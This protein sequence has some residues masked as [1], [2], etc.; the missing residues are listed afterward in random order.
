MRGTAVSEVRF[1]AMGANISTLKSVSSL[2]EVLQSVEER[3]FDIEATQLHHEHGLV[4]NNFLTVSGKQIP[5]NE[6]TSLL[7]GPIIGCISCEACWLLVEVNRD[8]SVSCFVFL[9]DKAIN[10]RRFVHSK[11]F[12]ITAAQP[13]AICISDLT[14]CCEYDVYIGGIC[15]SQASSLVA[16][17]TTLSTTLQCFRGIVLYDGKI[18]RQSPNQTPFWDGISASVA[19]NSYP[20]MLL[21]LG[22][23]LELED[24]VK[25]YCTK[26]VDDIL[27]EGRS[28][29]QWLRYLEEFE[30]RVKER[31]RKALT[32]PN[33]LRIGR[34][35]SCLLVAGEN[36]S[37]QK[38]LQSFLELVLDEDGSYNRSKESSVVDGEGESV[39]SAGENASIMGSTVNKEV[40]SAQ[41]RRL[42]DSQAKITLIRLILSAVARVLR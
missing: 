15:Y 22:N 35:C 17:F 24:V 7:T 4:C 33:M 34:T 12:K 41:A 32:S 2:N 27:C 39:F 1:I 29:Q 5:C 13:L 38:L 23:L 26:L 20:V 36:E 30:E 18:E 28:V 14:P 21:S 16:S 11:M 25:L 42:H 19:V 10:S 6:S 8:C 9:R 3:L 37:A 31:Y 40:S